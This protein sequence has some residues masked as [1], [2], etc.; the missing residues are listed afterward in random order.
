MKQL[1]AAASS[2]LPHSVETTVTQIMASD[3]SEMQAFQDEV[4]E[5]KQWWS[6]SR[7]RNT[8]RP[9]TAEQIADKRGNLKIEYPSNAMSKK[10]WKIVEKRFTVSKLEKE[11]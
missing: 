10:M 6:D 7:W 5:I 2:V 3:S 8:R 9:Y 11:R 1:V 4:K